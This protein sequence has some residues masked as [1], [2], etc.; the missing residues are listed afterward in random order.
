MSIESPKAMKDLQCATAVALKP[1]IDACL[2][3][4]KVLQTILDKTLP[5]QKSSSWQR[6]LLALRSLMRGLGAN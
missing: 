2:N 6:R 5:P 1:L 4:I 3:E